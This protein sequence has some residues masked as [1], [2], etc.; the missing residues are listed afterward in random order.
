MENLIGKVSPHGTP[1]HPSTE[2]AREES[3]LEIRVDD[4]N[5]ILYCEY[6]VFLSSSPSK[7]QRPQ[8]LS[9]PH[10]SGRLTLAAY[11][12]ASINTLRNRISLLR[13]NREVIYRQSKDPL[14]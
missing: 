7:A 9:G 10:V 5:R 4:L 3:N 13:F 1:L 11:D 8:N 12:K 14:F 2:T 6:V